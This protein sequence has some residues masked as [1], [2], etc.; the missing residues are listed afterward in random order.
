MEVHVVGL[1]SF[2]GSMGL[3]PGGSLPGWPKL[4]LRISGAQ[5]LLGWYRGLAAT[6]QEFVPPLSCCGI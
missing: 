4:L 6:G 2:L 5:N 3:V 1:G